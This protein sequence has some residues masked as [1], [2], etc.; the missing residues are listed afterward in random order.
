M[1]INE[2]IKSHNM[3]TYILMGIF[4]VI[5]TVILQRTCRC[6]FLQYVFN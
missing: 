3:Y 6:R 4:I 5:M 2:V 1:K